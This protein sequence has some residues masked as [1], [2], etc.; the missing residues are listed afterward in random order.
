VTQLLDINDEHVA[1]ADSTVI[2][3]LRKAL[4]EAELADLGTEMN[5]EER[6][7]LTH[8]HPN[9]PTSGPLAGAARKAAELVDRVRDRSAD[10]NRTN[11]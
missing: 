9:V 1:S 11:S 5:S 6:R 3:G 10:V 7:A 8:A 4:T 2:P